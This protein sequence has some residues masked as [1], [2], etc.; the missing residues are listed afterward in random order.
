MPGDGPR[1]WPRARVGAWPVAGASLTGFVMVEQIKS[2]DY[3]RRQ[4]RFVDKAP[5]SVLDEA[6]AILDACLY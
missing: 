5:G 1:S 4:V 3:V 6:L 2:L